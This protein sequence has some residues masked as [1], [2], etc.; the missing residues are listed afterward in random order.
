MEGSQYPIQAIDALRD[1]ALNVVHYVIG[2]KLGASSKTIL[3]PHQIA[4]NLVTAAVQN[5]ALTASFQT[6]KVTPAAWATRTMRCKA[7]AEAKEKV[8][9][10][11]EIIGCFLQNGNTEWETMRGKINTTY[12]QLAEKD[13]WDGILWPY[14]MCTSGASI[15]KF[16][17]IITRSD[18]SHCQVH[19]QRRCHGQE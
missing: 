10:D 16:L 11:A 17:L 18:C 2:T 19:E 9:I 13:N 7:I 5:K 1:L 4:F 8:Y 14:G 12:L 6:A 3:S 15:L